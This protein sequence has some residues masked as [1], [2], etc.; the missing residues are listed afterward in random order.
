M[1]VLS[2]L[3]QSESPGIADNKVLDQW[4]I[5]FGEWVEQIVRWVDLNLGSVLNV[6]EWPF[7][8][9]FRNFVDGPSHHPW[10]EITDMPW[11]AVCALFFLVGTLVRNVRV[12]GFVA[13]A[14]IGCGMLGNEYWEETALTLGM[15]VVAVV[16]CAIIGIPLGVLCGRFDGVWNAVRPALDAMQVIHSF[17]YMLPVIFFFGIGPEP[18]TMVTMVFAIP[19]LIRLTNLGIRQVPGDV[20]E[21][22]RAYG[23]PEWRVLTDVQMPL[24]RPAIMTGLNQ[25]LLLSISM[26]GIAAIM[27]AGGLGLLV[28]RAVQNLDTALAASAGL[29][30]FIVA[31]VL[32]R[33]S[34][35][36][37]TDSENFFKRIRRAWVHR[38]DPES[39]L[40]Q[41][42]SIGAVASTQGEP[43]PLTGREHRCLAVTAVG[44]IV[45]VV[46]VFLPWGYDSG[47]ISGYA[48]LIDTGRY[49]YVETNPNGSP[50][51]VELLVASAN[52]PVESAA[53][54]QLLEGQRQAAIA[55]AESEGLADDETLDAINDE[56]AHL[57]NPLAGRG[58][59]GLDAS[60]GSFY[61]IS[62]L[63]LSM[64]VLAAVITNWRRIGRAMRLFASNG[65]LALCAGA[66]AAAIAYL[67]ASPA[68]AN[69]AYRGGIGPWVAVTGGVIAVVGAALW[70]REA[71][72]SARRPLRARVN[73]G[74]IGVAVF[75]VALL[76]IAGFSGWSFDGRAESV[77]S[78][79]LEAQIA[80]LEQQA[81]DDPSLEVD[82]SAQ[83]V[84]LVSTAQRTETVVIDGFARTGTRYG[85]LTLGLGVLGL[86][87]ALPAAGVFGT[88]EIWRRRWNAAVA[89]AG[90]GVMIVSAIWISSL[91]RVA[92]PKFASGAGAFLCFV[93]GLVLMTTTASTLREFDRSQ[94]YVSID[95]PEVMPE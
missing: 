35:T 30:L 89:S 83:I 10:W 44:A 9:L 55:A 6:I 51:E 31:V 26:L 14:L 54:I 25:T 82:A 81:R 60:G 40:P 84:S 43:A 17:V 41:A 47:K 94:V 78:P 38:R 7:T 75:A 88:D 71:P 1:S 13:V 2:L 23:A 77:L 61:G 28:F 64:L 93:G 19:P 63:G 66:L 33:I 69:V 62:V 57:S 52:P 3:A 67:W 58:F 4:T 79:E 12:G 56:I 15:I 34:Q 95:E 46:A 86:V 21:A 74:Q 87:F 18:A 68:E 53:A 49:E 36:E 59:N 45:A 90:V 92:D 48:R 24:A 39:L 5:P 37:E 8:F 50:G 85:F 22:S 42:T 80:S 16:L 76:I 91:L 73:Y 27:G 11:I 70:L 20:V 32:D 65:V 29:A 72:Y